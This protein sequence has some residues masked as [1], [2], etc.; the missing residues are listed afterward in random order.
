MC[1]N[2]VRQLVNIELAI[3]QRHHR[4]V[5]RVLLCDQVVTVEQQKCSTNDQCGS[6]DSVEKH[7]IARDGERILR[8]HRSNVWRRV[9][10]RE[11]ILRASNCRF[12][13]VAIPQAV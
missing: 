2:P 1:T 11:Q 4:L 3:G 13:S 6:F 5:F 10:I 8:R 9:S 12:K 7:L